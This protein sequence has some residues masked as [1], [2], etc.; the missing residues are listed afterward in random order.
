MEKLL[1][2]YTDYLI[3]STS[4]ASATGLSRLLDNTV[5]HDSI[6]RFLGTNHFDSK[7]LWTSVKTLVREQENVNACLVF[8]DCIIEN[9]IPMRTHL[10][11]GIGI[12]Q[13]DALPKESTC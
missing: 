3:S 1:D 10:F 4:Q 8:D 11:V 12:M 13:R 5:S 2:F 6:T 7:S 9:S